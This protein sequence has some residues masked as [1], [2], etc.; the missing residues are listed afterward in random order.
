MRATGSADHDMIRRETGAELGFLHAGKTLSR[1]VPVALIGFTGVAY[2]DRLLQNRAAVLANYTRIVAA[3]RDAEL[4]SPAAEW[5][6]D[7]HYVVEESFRHLKRDLVPRYYRK[8]PTVA[9][10]DHGDTPAV[11]AFAW[12]YV[13]LTNSEFRAAT[14]TEMV[15]GYQTERAFTIGELWAIP[16]MLRLVLLENL[17]RISDQVMDAR[18]ARAAANA[19]ADRLMLGE[20]SASAALEGDSLSDA[21]AAQLLYRLRDGSRA[22]DLALAH[23]EQALARQD[24]DS[25][26]VLA[27]ENA[28]QSASNVAVGNVIRSMRRLDDTNWIKW[29]ERV[30]RV[31]AVLAAAPD[32]HQLDQATRNEYRHAIERIARRTEMT[33]IEVAERAVEMAGQGAAGHLL[34][35]HQREAFE[36]A[37]AYAPTL[38]ERILSRARRAGWLAIFLPMILLTL[39]I[40]IALTAVLPAMPAGVT[41]LFFVLTLITGSEAAVGVVNLLGARLIPVSRLPAYDY[42]TGVPEDARTLVAVPCLIGDLDTVD[43]LVLLLELHYLANPDGAI[44]FALITDWPDSD[45]EVSDTDRRVLEYACNEIAALC[46]RYAH[47]GQRFYL[48]HRARVWNAVDRRWMGWERKR[49]KLAELNSLLL[50]QGETTFMDVSPRPPVDVRFVV[51]LDSDT[52]LPRGT[53]A[54]LVGKM[55]HPVNTPV[56]DP[57]T[58]LVTSGHALMQPRVTPSLSTGADS[59]VFQNVFSAGRGMDPYVF[60]VSDLYQD[61]LDQGSFTG[62]GIYDIKAFDAAMAGRFPENAVLSHDLFEGSLARAALVTDVQVVED[63]PIRYDVDVS[64]QHRWIRGDWQLLPFIFDRRNGLGGLARMKMADNLRR[65]L[66]APAWVLSIILGWLVLPATYGWL[67]GLALVVSLFFMPLMNFQLGLLP[68]QRDAAR[69]RHLVRIAQDLG[70]HLSEIGLRLVFIAHQACSA[71]D[72]IGR[73]LWRLTV[74]RRRMLEWRTAQQVQNVGRRSHRDWWGAMIGSPVIGALALTLTLLL[75]PAAWPAATLL[76]LFWIAAPGIAAAVSRSLKIEDSLQVAP[77]DEADLRRVARTTWRYFETFVTAETHD[78]PPDNFQDTPAPKLAERTS[79]TNIGLY[80]LSVL[81]ARDLGWIGQAETIGRIARTVSTLE[82]MERYRGH[83][84]NWYDTRDLSVMQPRYVSSV[85][86]GNLAGHLIAVS[87][88][89]TDWS[90]NPTVHS[91]GNL[92]GIGDTLAV[93]VE[94]LAQVPDDRRTLRA[95]RRRLEE[96]IE[97]FGRSH[98]AYI[99][100]PQLATLRALNLRLIAADIVR[101]ATDFDAESERAATSE[102]LWWAQALRANCDAIV[103]QADESAPSR[104]AQAQTLE[105]LAQRLRKLAFEMDFALLLN[106]EKRLLSIGYR[107][108]SD[109]QDDSCY[110]LL[111]SEARLASLF[112][113]AKGDVPTTHWMRLGRPVTSIGTRGALLS[114]SGSMFEYLMPPLV[115]HERVGGVLHAAS[116]MAVRAQMQHGHRLNLPWGVSESAFSARDREMNYQ[117]YA[118][119]VPMLA[120]KRMQTTDHVIAPYATLMAAQ[121]FPRAAVRNLQRLNGLGAFGPYGYFD[122]VDFTASRMPEGQEHV[123]VRT[124]MAHHHGMSIVA[125]A[126]VVLDGIH[127]DRFHADPVIKAAELLLQEK[128]HRDVV[129][130]TRAA[131]FE[132]REGD[133]E[134]ED[135]AITRSDD[136]ASDTPMLA[137]LSNGRLSS[138]VSGTGAGP[139]WLDHV[140]VTRWR[141]DPTLDTGGIFLFLSDQDSGDWWS[142]TT[143]PRAAKGETAQAVFCDHKAEFFKT[144]H[145]IESCME[146]IVASEAMGEGRRLTLRNASSRKRTIEV[147]SY[148]EI[149]LDRADADI[150]HPAYSKMF[151]KTAIRDDGRTITA[152]RN[153]RKPDD[154]VLHM[155]HILAG[156]SDIRPA[157]AETD[158]RA[159]I[160]R[161]RDLGHAA[162]FDKGA[163]LGG[164]DGFT[165]DPIFAIRRRVTIPAGK[166]VSL[167]FWTLVADSA[168]ALE[169]V[170]RHHRQDDTFAHEDRMAWSMSQVQLRHAA[171]SLPEAALFRQVAAGLIWPDPRLAI[172]DETLHD[173]VGRQSALWPMGISGDHPI[174]LLRTDDETD[175]EI[176]RKA[177]RMA[178]YFRMHGLQADLVILNERQSSYTQDLQSAIQN[179]CDMAARAGHLDPSQRN[180]FAVRRD[181]MSDESFATLLATARIVLHTRNGKISDQMARLLSQAEPAQDAES[182]RPTLLPVRQRGTATF[183]QEDF[184]AWNGTGGFSADGKE[185]VIRMRHGERTPHPWINVIAQDDFGFHVSAGGAAFNWAVNS[186]DYQISPWSNDPVINRPGEAILIRNAT[187][188]QVISPFAALSDDPVAL[189]EARHGLGRS[190]FRVWTDWVEAEAVM[191]LLPGAPARLTG[192]T[193]RHKGAGDLKVEVTA[194]VELVLGNN[195]DRTSAVIRAGHDTDL[196]AVLGR[197]D[198]GTGVTGRVTALAASLPLQDVTVSRGAFLG[199]NGALGRPE[200]LHDW[201]EVDGTEGDPC[202]AARVGLTVSKGQERSVTFILADAEKGAMADVLAQARVED[203]LSQALKKTAATWEAFLGQLQIDTPDPQMN[204]LVNTWLPY[205]ALTCRLKARSAFYQASGA[206]GFRDQLQDSSA[207]ILQ[208]RS[209]ARRQILNAAGR[210]FPEGDVQHWWLPNS[211]AGVR[212]MIS[213]DVVWLGHITARYV[214]MTGDQAILD[215]ELPFLEG[216]ALEPG[217][218]DAFFTPERSER[219]VPVYEHCALALDLAI[220]RMGPQGLPLMLGGDWNDGM[221][222][223]G[224]GGQG[225]SVWLGWFLMTTL[226]AFL[227]I[228][229]AR[230]D[231][232]RVTAWTAH[233][234][235]LLEA[236][237]TAGW[238]GGWYRRATY[239]DGT[240]LGSTESEDCQIDSIAQSWANL[241]GAG[242]PDRARMA[243]DAVM[244]ELADRDDG[245]LRL[246]KPPFETGDKEPGYIKGYPPGVRENGGQYTHAATWVVHALGRAGRGTEAMEMF[247]LINPIAHALTPEEVERYRV[248]PYVVAADVYGVGDLT[249]RGG[250]TWY[251]GSASWLYRAAVEGILG[252]QLDNGDRLRVEPSLPESW[253]GFSARVRIGGHEQRIV[254]SREAGGI[255]VTCD[256]EVVDPA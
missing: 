184:Q 115:M 214:T 33:E 231:T 236:L 103:G 42:D 5:L 86:S 111:A 169:E 74:S 223:V 172:Q 27:R 98:A 76:C 245:V 41:V 248:E 150:A 216:P 144:A 15:D 159:F 149:V 160:G 72:A 171:I 121:F 87:S 1:E 200:A 69:G 38:A 35:G 108:D 192:L 168:E 101:H 178:D 28:R 213:D 220:A 24:T 109:E 11:L 152:F 39:L 40:A 224:E 20:D 241:S 204:L 34:V 47:V 147:T 146:V 154:R 48:L 201:P 225:E 137:L 167:T 16:A 23:L 215:E 117:Y 29:V 218:H 49:G 138:L 247:D 43:E 132:P 94:R 188:G 155:A 148:G 252:I 120:L 61:L 208:D 194:Y 126:N 234:V 203:A 195:R 116:V 63:F 68:A 173:S 179:M 85:D 235:A 212:T 230:G 237:E 170:I 205:Q 55:M 26:Q 221:N 7:N 19:L 130:L 151:V 102:V 104:G 46:A 156:A 253:P 187:T 122:A 202:L 222:R 54:A 17:R 157:E 196:D 95:M 131:P 6:L 21:F 127:R 30:S 227:P 58:G 193:L 255:K 249:G 166:S 226:D 251:T 177:I 153:R 210:Q 134:D 70:A 99:A 238:D 9:T 211:G 78:L 197:N 64:R 62:K 93:L 113:I 90:K 232:E 22:A 44:D 229:E 81:S 186:R 217:A 206:Y 45:E 246:L 124:V 65:S 125:I 183:P 239:D 142:A 143:T 175:L 209:L 80:L 4:I 82:G 105:D 37:C 2:P 145:G 114:W 50:G 133:G 228:A 96:L 110:D 256:K 139:L 77:G 191:T 91:H 31:D 100:E 97:G 107:P 12:R 14:L 254:V 57:E 140:A 161:G 112:A 3:V 165:L 13:S 118:F 242:D 190:T 243:L 176:V 79:P 106:P 71:A 18:T 240:P 158:R 136:P 36:R 83:F 135:P 119:G 92:T 66:V 52:R 233:R 32:F 84:Y 207:L 164:A 185:Y 199:R 8:L 75:N 163:R 67:W 174:L 129:P 244:R 181:Q 59:S 51:T 219:S 53:V 162:A 141:P 189:H 25:A 180:V 10:Q 56:T 123:V 198:F 128:T 182:P 89:L 60:T 73:T 250:W 88:A